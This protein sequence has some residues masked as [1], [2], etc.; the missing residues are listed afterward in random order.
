MKP[1][2]APV[3]KKKDGS[4]VCAVCGRSAEEDVRCGCQYVHIG[5]SFPTHGLGRKRPR[6]GWCGHVK[7]SRRQNL[8]AN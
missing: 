6:R 8:T 4:I 7:G 5:T 2:K 1:V 3:R